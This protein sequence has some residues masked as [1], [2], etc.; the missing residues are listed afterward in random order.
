MKK[1]TDYFSRKAH[2][3]KAELKHTP[4]PKL[5]AVSFVI[6]ILNIL[7]IFV[8]RSRLPPEV[9]LF[10]GFAEG[11][12]QLTNTLGLTIPSIFA[13]SVILVNNLISLFVGNIFLKQILILAGFVVT[14]FATVTTYKIILLV[15][16][17]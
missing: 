17:F 10:Y 16:S 2:K 7:I 6:N 1:R 14:I 3:T 11:E 5:I 8:F 15:G 12:D 13:L 4:Y 9:P